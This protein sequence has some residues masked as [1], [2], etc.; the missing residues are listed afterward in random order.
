MGFEPRLSSQNESAEDIAS[1]MKKVHKETSSALKKAANDMKKYTSRKQS[2]A[3][4]YKI[5]DKCKG[6]LVSLT[7]YYLS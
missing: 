4:E 7:L 3:P 6:T 2:D 1:H 5:G